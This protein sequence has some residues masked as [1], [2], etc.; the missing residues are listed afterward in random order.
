MVKSSSAFSFLGLIPIIIW[1]SAV[2][3][4][5]SITRTVGPLTAA[6]LVYFIA[7]SLSLAFMALRGNLARDVRGLSLKPF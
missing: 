3:L 5:G 1:G 6:G 7:G 2:G 4:T